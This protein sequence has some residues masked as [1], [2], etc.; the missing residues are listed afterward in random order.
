MK[1]L[2]TI[3]SQGVGRH[4]SL[5]W[6]RPSF[7]LFWGGQ[8]LSNLGD[9]FALVAIPLLVLQVTGSAAQMG[10]VTAT[11]GTGRLLAGIFAGL[12]VDRVDRRMFMIACDASRLLLFGSIPCV[13]LLA[14][15][16]LWLIYVVMTGGAIIGMG[17]QAA[18]VTAVVN[19]VETEQITAA[20][21]MLQGTLA[22]TYV[23]GPLLAGIIATVLSPTTAVGVDALRD[24]QEIKG[25]NQAVRGKM[26]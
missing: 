9:A 22:L 12:L 16:Q 5:F 1:Q 6:Q 20:N 24:C 7:L 11:F 21:S 2:E 25:A 4:S 23:L 19:L 26:V 13:W 15:P 18:Y 14:G 17:F 8:S 3:A 10:L